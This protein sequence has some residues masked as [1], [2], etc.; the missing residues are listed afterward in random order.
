MY[1]AMFF[2]FFCCFFFFF[3]NVCVG[4]R[5]WGG[6]ECDWDAKRNLVVSQTCY[7]FLLELPH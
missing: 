4:G 2:L 1:T 5:G 3:V 6:V 7:R